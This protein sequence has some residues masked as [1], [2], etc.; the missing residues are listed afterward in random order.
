MHS[1]GGWRS[2]PGP[3]A[4]SGAST[5]CCSPPR[6]PRSSSTTSA[7][8][9][10]APAP[11]PARPTRWSRRSSAMGGEAVANG[12]D[13]AD[14][15]GAQRLINSRHRGVRRPRHPRQQRRHPARPGARQHDR[16]GVGR[17]RAGPPQGP[18]RAEPLGR[19]L[20]AGGGQGRPRQAAQHRP[21]VEH[22]GAVRQPRPEQLRRGQVGHRHVQPDPGQGAGPLRASRATASPRP[23]APA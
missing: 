13:V 6:A 20:L 1:T 22:V 17:R 23:P 11:T 4:A 12:D 14:W 21:H 15:D 9:T 18:L 2:S 8:P 5:R 16:G 7:A 3:G 10:T 19:R